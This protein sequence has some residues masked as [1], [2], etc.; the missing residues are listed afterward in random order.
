MNTIS[1]LVPFV[2][3]MLATIL[4]IAVVSRRSRPRIA[5]IDCGDCAA[6]LPPHSVIAHHVWQ[7]PWRVVDADELDID[8]IILHSDPEQGRSSASGMDVLKH[9]QRHDAVPGFLVCPYPYPL[10]LAIVREPELYP[11]HWQGRRVWFFVPFW[12][13][14]PDQ[15]DGSK[16][17]PGAKGLYV[18]GIEGQDGRPALIRRALA[19]NFGPGDVLAVKLVRDLQPT[20]DPVVAGD[21]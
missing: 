2:A 20:L 12:V 1:S 16:P 5:K 11:P 13:D 6:D 14:E 8:D 9:L 18:Y 4:V 7:V 17:K 3:A 21:R 15:T 19:E 10:A